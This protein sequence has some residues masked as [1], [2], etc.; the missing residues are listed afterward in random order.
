M[1]GGDNT[2]LTMAERT[3]RAMARIRAVF[4]RGSAVSEPTQK[5]VGRGAVE[6]GRVLP[7]SHVSAPMPPVQPPR[8]SPTQSAPDGAPVDV[9]VRTAHGLRRW[10]MP[11]VDHWSITALPD[12]ARMIEISGSRPLRAD[13]AVAAHLAWLL[14][15]EEWRTHLAFYR[16]E[17][18]DG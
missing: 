1:A 17:C 7:T 9:W 8:L 5:I 13:A 12:G 4:R 16:A 14:M 15:P 10:R 11:I 3:A 18:G 2:P 6:K